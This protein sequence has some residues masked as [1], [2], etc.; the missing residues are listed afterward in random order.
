MHYCYIGI[1]PICNFSDSIGEI[2][3]KK[4]DGIAQIR[5][6][7]RTNFRENEMNQGDNPPVGILLCNRNGKKMDAFVAR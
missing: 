7:R 1:A 2:C 3:G 4:C 5:H 6:S